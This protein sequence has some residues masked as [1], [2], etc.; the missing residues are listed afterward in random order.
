MHCQ[1]GA[2]ASAT[3]VIAYLMYEKHQK[4]EDRLCSVADILTYDQAFD[5]VRAARPK[6]NPNQSFR[7]QLK[8]FE[9]QLK[10]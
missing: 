9:N 10:F 5:I 7:I 3:M 2:S 8:N 4:Y 6:V 1:E